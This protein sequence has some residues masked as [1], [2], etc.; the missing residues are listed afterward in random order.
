M[1]SM[2]ASICGHESIG[3]VVQDQTSPYYGTIPAA[4]VLC[5]QLEV[6]ISSTLQRT[7]RTRILQRL[8]KSMMRSLRII[9]HWFIMYLT[10]FIMHTAAL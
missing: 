5:A 4:S 7:L 6:I 8:K 10:T 1:L 9:T 2:P 3:A